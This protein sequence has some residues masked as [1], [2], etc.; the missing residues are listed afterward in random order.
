MVMLMCDSDS[1]SLLELQGCL[2]VPGP[3]SSA[4]DPPKFWEKWDWR[5]PGLGPAVVFFRLPWLNFR[6]RG[7]EEAPHSTTYFFTLISMP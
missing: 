3:L 5:W 7:I 2:R 6:G 4:A 1:Q